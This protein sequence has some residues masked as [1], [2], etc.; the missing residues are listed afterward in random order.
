MWRLFSRIRPPKN[1]IHSSIGPTFL[2]YVEA[3]REEESYIEDSGVNWYSLCQGRCQQ[4]KT[5]GTINGRGYGV[6]GVLMY[7]NLSGRN[8]D[9]IS[10]G[11]TSADATFTG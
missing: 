9:I 10:S 2:K 5:W 11:G 4:E 3:L 1:R 8:S 6:G 7:S